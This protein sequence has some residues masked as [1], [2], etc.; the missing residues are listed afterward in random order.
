MPPPE[1][2]NKSGEEIFEFKSRYEYMFEIMTDWY[3]VPLLKGEL[4]NHNLNFLSR[5]T[6]GIL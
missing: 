2:A 5:I 3:I 1:Y 4:L 6:I